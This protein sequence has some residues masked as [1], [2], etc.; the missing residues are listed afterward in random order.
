MST[1]SD[2]EIQRA[3]RLVECQ[4]R[5]SKAYYVRHRDAIKAKSAEYWQTHKATINA[6]RRAHYAQ[7]HPTP[8]IS[9]VPLQ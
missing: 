3:L 2:A 6:R 1:T 5:A 4:R 7:T 8:E 9:S